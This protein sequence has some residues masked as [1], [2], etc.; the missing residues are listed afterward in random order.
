M[1]TMSA[2]TQT[3]CSRVL[4]LYRPSWSPLWIIKGNKCFRG[5]SLG[6][7]LKKQLGAWEGSREQKRKENYQETERRAKPGVPAGEYLGNRI[8]WVIEGFD[9]VFDGGQGLRIVLGVDLDF[10]N[11]PVLRS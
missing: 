4:S 7:H 11:I 5:S 8:G 1:S 10:A 2:R 9:V 3:L 6:L